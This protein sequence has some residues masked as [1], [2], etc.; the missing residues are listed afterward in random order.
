MEYNLKTKPLDEKTLTYY[1]ILPESYIQQALLSQESYNNVS[2]LIKFTDNVINTL[3]KEYHQKLIEQTE[4]LKEKSIT[5]NILDTIIHE[6]TIQAI[7]LYI[8]ELLT[9]TYT[10]EFKDKLNL[11]EKINLN[12]IDPTLAVNK[13]E[14]KQYYE[15]YADK[16]KEK[17]DELSFEDIRLAYKKY[18]TT[19]TL[20]DYFV[21]V[22]QNIFEFPK[23]K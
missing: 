22:I 15:F 14:Q 7:K 3:T 8:K 2:N 6:L 16:I 5:L 19:N 21:E 9:I 4:N 10:H 17:M 1:N 23:N 11:I 18:I 12:H 20:S 13:K